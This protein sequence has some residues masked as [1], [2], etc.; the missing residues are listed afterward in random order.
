[1]NNPIPTHQF[2]DEPATFIM[3]TWQDLQDLTFEIAQQSRSAGKNY[4][5]V[6]TLA[7]GGWPMTRSLVDFLEVKKVASIGIKFYSGVDE[8][9]EKPQIYQDLPE[10][11]VGEK[12]I[13][14][15]DV[16]DTGE[17]LVFAR[18]HLLENGVAEV[19][20][21]SIFYK[22][23]SKIKP[24]FF[25][26]QTEAWVIF[27]YEVSESID[28]LSTRWQ[29]SGLDSAEISD[30]LRKLGYTNQHLDLYL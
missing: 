21:A 26:Q 12:V 3:P 24:T 2:P 5:R 10:E 8:R 11:V 29:R 1:M 14:F 20:T 7:K 25:A 9:L 6:V 22:E 4:D 18:D 19:D 15:D 17:S 27:P 28:V 23:H 16:A 30:R 13:L